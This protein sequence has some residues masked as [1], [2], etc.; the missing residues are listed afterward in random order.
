VVDG[1]LIT[2]ERLLVVLVVLPWLVVGRSK[3][4]AFVVQILVEELLVTFL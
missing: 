3:G 1:R 4:I 2:G